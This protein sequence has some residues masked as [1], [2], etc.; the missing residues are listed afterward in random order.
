MNSSLNAYVEYGV[1]VTLL[2]IL[3]INVTVTSGRTFRYL[4]T[5][6]PTGIET[7]TR[8]PISAITLRMQILLYCTTIC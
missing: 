8:V 2:I 5:G 7:G 3:I 4:K 1:T 6:Y